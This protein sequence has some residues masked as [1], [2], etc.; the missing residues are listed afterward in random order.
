MLPDGSAAPREH[1]R[2]RSREAAGRNGAWVQATRAGAACQSAEW[3]SRRRRARPSVPTGKWFQ[4]CE[5]PC[6]SAR[7]VK[8]AGPCGGAPFDVASASSSAGLS[9]FFEVRQIPAEEVARA[10]LHLAHP[11]AR[12][13]P[14]LAEILQRAGIV[15]GQAVAQDVPRQLA[16]ALA[17]LAERAANV[18][19]LLGA[20]Q[21]RVGARA[22]V[23]EAVQMRGVAVAVRAQRLLQRDVAR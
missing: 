18:L 16:H 14:L 22:L 19:V 5:R 7:N 1:R 23:G 6:R 20:E 4:H 12:E 13:A 10:L 21:L 3:A 9:R 15:L 8:G 11:L 2:R 17:H